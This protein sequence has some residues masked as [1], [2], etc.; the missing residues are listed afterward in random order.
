MSRRVDRL[1]IEL[2]RAVQQVITRGLQDPRARGLITVT[3][4][5][6][7]K[8][9][10][11][12]AVHISVLPHEHEDLTL[13]A[14]KDAAKHIRRQAGERVAMSR[15]P[16]FHFKL[17]STLKKQ[18]GVISAI[19]MQSRIDAKATNEDTPDTHDDS[20]GTTP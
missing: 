15:L 4:V 5:E 18:A 13:H 7:A 10:R 14:L 3:K 17:D 1:N 19:A 11:D 9:L 12:A 6:V 8:D 20:E 16:A 2:Q